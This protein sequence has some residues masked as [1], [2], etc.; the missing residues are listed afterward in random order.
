MARPAAP[1]VHLVVGGFP[2]GSTAGHDMHYAR[3][4]LLQ[5]V[6][7]VNHVQPTI[8]SNF[9]DLETWLPTSQLLITYTSGPFPSDTALTHLN[10]WL[11]R[12]GRWLALHSEL[13]SLITHRFESSKSTSTVTTPSC[14]TCPRHLKPQTSCTSSKFSTQ[15]QRS[16]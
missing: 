8:S 5:F 7:E 1:G 9:A 6:G 2:P 4:E 14:T 15:T 16:C 3:T 12:G 10:S 11:E 13:F